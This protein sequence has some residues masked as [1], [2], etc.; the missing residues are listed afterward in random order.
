MPRV[1]HKHTVRNRASTPAAEPEVV[2]ESTPRRSADG[3]HRD[4]VRIH[5]GTAGLIS[6]FIDRVFVNETQR[7]LIL[8]ESRHPGTVETA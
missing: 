5:S 8:S 4:C 1:R 2:E 7:A 6:A 3:K